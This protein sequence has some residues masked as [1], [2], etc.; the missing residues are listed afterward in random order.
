M[1]NKGNLLHAEMHNKLKNIENGKPI[2][3]MN[4]TLN[5]VKFNSIISYS[6][7]LYFNKELAVFVTSFHFVKWS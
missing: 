5:I 4:L 6:T 7:L 3:K 1:D 2:P